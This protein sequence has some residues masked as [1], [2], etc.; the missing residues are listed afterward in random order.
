MTFPS[1]GP[2]Y[3]QQ[4]GGAQPNP[5]APG[6]GGF[7]QQQGAPSLSSINLPMVLTLV[8]AVLGI[9][10]YFIGFSEEASGSD[11]ALLFLLVGGL[12]AG[13][14]ML[15]R[16]PKALPF[17]VLFSVLGGLYAI[18]SVVR[19]PSGADTPGI[20]TVILILGILQLLVAVAALL[21][22]YNVL[23]LPATGQRP[24]YPPYGQPGP[25]GQPQQGPEQQ[26]GPQGTQFVPPV[27]PQS[28]VYAPQHGQFYQPQQPESGPQQQ[29]QQ[30]GT[31]TPPGGFGQQS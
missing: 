6:P 15:P 17:A 20:M 3:P 1:G 19:V 9:V 22:E 18:L 24:A 4:G 13:L 28:T 29:Q 8:V 31:G 11:Q 14:S 23:K 10:N 12:L 16:G 26:G 27:A 30:P 2:G 7:P 21:F 25:Y 5:Q